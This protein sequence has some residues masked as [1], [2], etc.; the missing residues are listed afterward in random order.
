M[1]VRVTNTGLINLP[2]LNLSCALICKKGCFC[3]D[4]FIRDDSGKCISKKDCPG[5]C[6]GVTCPPDAYCL[7][8]EC[9][10]NSSG[11]KFVNGV[12][13]KIRKCDV[14]K[15][16]PNS[17]CSE[18]YG[19][20][21]DSG[22]EFSEYPER[23]KK[24]F[25]VLPETRTCVD[26]D[27]CSNNSNK[28]DE[29]AICTNTIGSYTCQC[30]EGFTGNGH[31]CTEGGKSEDCPCPSEECWTWNK[32]D[33]TCEF[34]EECAEVDCDALDMNVK[35][36]EAVFGKDNLK[37]TPKPQITPKIYRERRETFDREMSLS[38]ELGKC[39]MTHRL[40]PAQI[41]PESDPIDM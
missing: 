27:E 32:A 17:S 35:F 18:E 39:G 16:P 14:L 30:K 9:I 41:T 11:E 34:K 33:G 26:I 1:Q 7:K 15:C 21:C 36:V 5:S 6:G 40:A 19:C 3:E 4:G 13:E 24:R 22:Y 10:C 12:C 8:D 31:Y 29:N 2:T 38:C 25:S 28:C 37:I 20:V 23:R